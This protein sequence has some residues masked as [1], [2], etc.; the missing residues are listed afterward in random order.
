MSE[1]AYVDGVRII[2]SIGI[3]EVFY[4]KVNGLEVNLLSKKFDPDFPDANNYFDEF[5]I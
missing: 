2:A 3:C 5:G 4:N 1:N